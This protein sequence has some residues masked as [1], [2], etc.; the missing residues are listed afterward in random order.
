MNCSKKKLSTEISEVIF[1]MLKKNI[2]I[3]CSTN[4]AQILSICSLIDCLKAFKFTFER[5]I[6]S[7]LAL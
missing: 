3:V 7:V 4:S 5:N 6:Q 1:Y 2:V